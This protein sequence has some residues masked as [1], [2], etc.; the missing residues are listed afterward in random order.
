MRVECRTEIFNH[1]RLDVDISLQFSILHALDRLM[2]LAQDP[3]L[4]AG[5]GKL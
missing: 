3:Q 4:N 5:K 1:I 2:D